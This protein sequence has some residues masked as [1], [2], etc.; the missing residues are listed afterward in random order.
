MEIHLCT[1]KVGGRE[2][3][4]SPFQEMEGAKYNTLNLGKQQKGDLSSISP[5]SPIY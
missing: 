4:F 2:T 3:V 5:G 1:L